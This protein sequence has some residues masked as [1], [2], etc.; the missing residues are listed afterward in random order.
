MVEKMPDK[1]RVTVEKLLR[2]GRL[3]LVDAQPQRAIELVVQAQ[4]HV[5]SATTLASQD[6][7]GA[8]QLLYDGARKTMTAPLLAQ[9]LRPTGEGAHAVLSEVLLAQFAPPHGEVLRKFDLM[10]RLRNNAEYPSGPLVELS[11]HEVLSYVPHVKQIITL[12][13]KLLPQL[14]EF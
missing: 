10:R 4:K 11:S 2:D 8:F 1:G 12:V 6:G 9:G 7:T 3:Q 13:E 14:K 5:A